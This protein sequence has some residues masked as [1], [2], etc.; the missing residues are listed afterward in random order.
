[1]KEFTDQLSRKVEIPFPPKRII[2]L[3]PSQTELLYDLGLDHEVVGITKFCIHPQQWFNEKE[4]VGGTK[5]F[6]FDK[7]DE[8]QPDLIIGNRE[9]NY[10][11]GIAKLSN[12]HPVWMSDISDF[13]SALAMIHLVAQIT[14]REKQGNEIIQS[15]NQAFDKLPIFKPKRV[16]YLIWQGPWMAAGKSTFIDSM[17]SKLGWMNAVNEL[18]YPTLNEEQLR[19]LNPEVVLLSSEPYPFKEGHLKSIKK[20]FPN[21]SVY[22]VDGEPF[23]WYGSRM[24]QAPTYFATLPFLK[25]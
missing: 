6:W 23:S 21:A 2:S 3:V 8:L 16:L 1:M 18:R 11:E 12:K 13:E 22:L 24:I 20:F 10:E 15:I 17:I 25:L 5:N 19:E 14:N 7:I 4:K 9:E